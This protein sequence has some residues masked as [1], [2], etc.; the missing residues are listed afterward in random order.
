MVKGITGLP[1]KPENNR[2]GRMMTDK[3]CEADDR[4]RDRLDRVM[5]RHNPKWAEI[6]K[7]DTRGEA[8]PGHMEDSIKK[9]TS[10]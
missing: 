1:W 9:G 7:D 5:L 3:Q 4:E 2:Y 8:L 6:E 10:K